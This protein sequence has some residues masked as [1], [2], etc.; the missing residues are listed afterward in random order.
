MIGK[1]REQGII[2]PDLTRITGQD[3]KSV[4]VRTTM[5]KNQGYIEKKSVLVK[6]LNTSKLTLTRFAVQRDLRRQLQSAQEVKEGKEGKTKKARRQLDKEDEGPNFA[7][8]GPTI[9]TEK[10]I[11]A[12][13]V[14]LKLAKN[15]VL[16]HS[17]LKRK[18]VCIIPSH[19]Y[20]SC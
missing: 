19:L 15:R 6:N 5:L 1:H 7:W 20:N 14:E 16:M 10:L 3:K 2:Q 12:I 13:L 11:K 8:T 4:P 17:D 18:L 9:D